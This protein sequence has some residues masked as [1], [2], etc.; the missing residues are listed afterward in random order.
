MVR[1][2]KPLD[3]SGGPSHATLSPPALCYSFM[4]GAEQLVMQR[5]VLAYS[6]PPSFF[7]SQ[8]L[9]LNLIMVGIN[10]LGVS[11]PLHFKNYIEPQRGFVLLLAMN[12]YHITV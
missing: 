4:K 8:I 7:L 10:Y 3:L 2:E 1:E 9:N 6:Y 5:N 11:N 12:T